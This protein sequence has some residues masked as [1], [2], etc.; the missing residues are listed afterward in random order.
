MR[1]KINVENCCFFFSICSDLKNRRRT[2]YNTASHTKVVLHFVH[3]IQCSRR[4]ADSPPGG[5][6][7]SILFFV[8]F[9]KRQNGCILNDT[10]RKNQQ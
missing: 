4:T 2:K 1:I 10:E 6:F 5:L 3:F 8:C 9:H 7:F